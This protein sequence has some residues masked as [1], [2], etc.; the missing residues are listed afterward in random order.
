LA[1]AR[2]LD[3]HTALFPDA[4]R[5][6]DEQVH[7]GERLAVMA[8]RLAELDGAARPELDIQDAVEARV[9][10]LLADLV[11]PAKVTA[12]EK[13]GEGDRAF[14][15]ATSWLRSRRPAGSVSDAPPL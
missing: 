7:E 12:L 15:I 1:E 10:A 5:T 11:E 13:L 9:P 8:D 3:G 6:W 14:R 4:V 2:Y